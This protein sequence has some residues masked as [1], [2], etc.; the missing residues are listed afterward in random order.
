MIRHH[1][2]LC[3]LLLTLFGGAEASA[4]GIP[5]APDSCNPVFEGIVPLRTPNFDQAAIWKR[6]LGVQGIDRPRALM[7]VADDGVISVGES[8]PYTEKEGFQSPRLQMIRVAKDGKILVDKLTDVEHL[9]NV[10]DALLQ[11]ARVVVLVHLVEGTTH[12]AALVYLDGKGEK[13][14]QK[15]INDPDRQITPVGFVALDDGS[16]VVL[17]EGRVKKSI[18]SPPT[19][20]LMWVNQDGYVRATKEY[21]PGVDTIPSSIHKTPHGDLVMSGRIKTE[22][23]N[24]AGWIL[25][26]ETNGNLVMQRPY[27]RGAEATLREAIGLR[28]GGLLAIG[29]A[30]PSGTGDKAAWVVKTDSSGMSVWQKFLTGKYSYAAV[31]LVQLDDGRVMTLWAASPTSFGGRRFARLVTFS[32]EG[33]ILNDESFLEGSNS[34]PFRLIENKDSRVVL[35]MAETGFAQ[36]KTDDQMQYVTY[37]SW[38][39][40]LPDLPVYHNPCA[41]APDRKLDDLPE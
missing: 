27:S 20:I 11:K 18:A 28:D 24:Q 35:G 34:I 30:I 10:V 32:E 4:Q 3:T 23:G 7:R 38:I 29:D 21:M 5:A 12:R 2:L 6:T 19:T 37:D 16:F 25:V 17:A 13:R 9:E 31:D 41:S 14:D 39:M 1:L 26:T 40:A 36:N 15:I 22:K 8:T 33:A